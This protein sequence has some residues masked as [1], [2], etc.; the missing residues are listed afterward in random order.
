[1]VI[2]VAITGASGFVGRNAIVS[3][4]QDDFDV[5]AIVRPG[6]EKIF[7]EFGD[8]K[9]ETIENLAEASVDVVEKL[10]D[11]LVG[12][13]AVF[14]FTHIPDSDVKVF[15][16]LNTIANQNVINAAMRAGVKKF[17]TN[18]GLGV[19]NFGRKRETTN[20][21]FRMKR[22]LEDDLVRA[23]RAAGMRYVIFRPSYIIG[24][25][26]EL[27]PWIAEKIRGGETIFIVGNGRYR[28][29]PIFVKD[30][31]QI[32]SA[33]AR[34]NDYDNQTFDLVG[35]KKIPYI[36][37]VKLVGRFLMRDPDVQYVA[38]S[39]AVKRK[40]E[41]GMNEDEIDVMMSNEIGDSGM[42]ERTFDFNLTPLDK[43]LEKIIERTI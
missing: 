41:F 28:M 42:L 17:V 2:R 33:C 1:M 18:S 15:E 27:T 30:A 19:A 5:T 39:E 3:L 11:I 32:Y 24:K 10:S 21:Y 13:D 34:L 29:Q 4:V 25:G 40:Q 43:A 22:R 6:R 35:P 38:K 37:Y 7:R 36:D 14:H 8:I 16:R 9:V 26:D 20:G 12:M 23:W 31:A